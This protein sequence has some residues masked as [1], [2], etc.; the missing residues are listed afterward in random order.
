MTDIDS[1]L[2][3]AD[4]SD[5]FQAKVIDWMSLLLSG[6]SWSVLLLLVLVQG[7]L[8]VRRGQTIG[9]MMCGIRIVG[10]DASRSVSPGRLLFLRPLMG[11]AL[12]ARS[13]P[14]FVAQLMLLLLVADALM[15]FSA[16]RRCLHDHLAGTRVV[17]CPQRVASPA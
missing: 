12:L 7:Y 3:P 13:N 10:L 6:W 4:R 14:P 16:D 5:R 1:E 2:F 15:I 9:K 11:L 8:L 17:R